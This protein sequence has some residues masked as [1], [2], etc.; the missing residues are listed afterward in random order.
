MPDNYFFT[1]RAVDFLVF[2]F[3]DFDFNARVFKTFYK[4]LMA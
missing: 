2:E 4:V 1:K 3:V